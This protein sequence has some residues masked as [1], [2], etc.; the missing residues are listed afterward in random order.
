MN[1][2]ETKI[3]TAAALEKAGPGTVKSLWPGIVDIN[4]AQDGGCPGFWNAYFPGEDPDEILRNCRRRPEWSRFWDRICPFG[5][6]RFVAEDVYGEGRRT[7]GELD[8]MNV[9]TSAGDCLVR[10]F[11]EIVKGRLTSDDPSFF[12]RDGPDLVLIWPFSQETA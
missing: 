8:A 9:Y 5:D 12:L 2:S 10:I 3:M 1:G 11:N 4:E 6:L 7:E